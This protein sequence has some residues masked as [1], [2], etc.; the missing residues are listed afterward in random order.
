MSLPAG[1]YQPASYTLKDAG[2]ELGRFRVFGPVITAANHDAKVALWAALISAIDAITLGNPVKAVYAD[3]VTY[4]ASQPTNGAARELKLSVRYKDGTTYERL[5]VTV[6]TL[7]PAIPTY[8]VND[9]VRDAIILTAPS[10]ITDFI[11]A[12]QAFCVNPRTGNAVVITGLSVVGR[13]T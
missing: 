13:S 3:E 9:S 12:F 5:H 2:N 1:T 11:T 6:P 8:I 4:S 10:T 7:D